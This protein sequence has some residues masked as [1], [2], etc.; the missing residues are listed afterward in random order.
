M[1]ASPRTTPAST[2]ASGDRSGAT[3]ISRGMSPAETKIIEAALH[4]REGEATLRAIVHAFVYG[5][6]ECLNGH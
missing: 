4:R 5:H 3:K 6:G 2:A 1:T